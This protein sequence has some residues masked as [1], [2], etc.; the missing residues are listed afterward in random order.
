MLM[1]KEHNC[2]FGLVL[3]RCKGGQN[4][5]MGQNTH[6]ENDF[7]ASNRFQVC[8]FLFDKIKDFIH[9]LFVF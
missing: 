8:W 9:A 3:V 7:I 5:L 4:G 6:S 1:Q 2:W